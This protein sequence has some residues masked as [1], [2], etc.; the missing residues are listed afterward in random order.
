MIESLQNDKIKKYTKLNDKKY[1]DETNMFIAPGK[2]LVNE[3]LKRGIVVEVF[4]LFGEANIY[5]EVTFT[6]S[7][8]L[9]KLSHL[10]SAPKVLA[11]CKKITPAEIKGNILILDNISDPG[12]LG[13]II[14]SA[15]CFNYETLILSPN[16]VDVYNPKVI[17]ATEGMLFNINVIIKDILE[18]IPILK[19]DNYLIYST[20]LKKESNEILKTKHAL[21]IGSEA[22]GIKP[23]ILKLCHKNIKIKMNPKCESLNAAVAASIL[24]HK[25][26]GGEVL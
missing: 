24:M 2:H 26:N 22:N 14:R 16:T 21:I 19:K 23:E 15:I 8:V 10:T 1:R 7:E 4:L 11:I 25:L 12:N 18:V 3:A 6:N 5:G 20:D 13:T 17:R 9:K